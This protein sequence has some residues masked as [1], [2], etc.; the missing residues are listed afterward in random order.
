MLS[1]E[2]RVERGIEVLD[3]H[4]GDNRWLAR[5]NID[6]LDLA[7]PYRCV[8]GQLFGNYVIGLD[9]LNGGIR[10]NGVFSH[11]LGFSCGDLGDK[12]Q[13]DLLTEAWRQALTE[14]IMAAMQAR[15]N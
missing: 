9:S 5:V 3:R 2:E 10:G 12:C 8:L 1:L 11:S 15:K 4:F 13:C 14:R 6:L 7:D